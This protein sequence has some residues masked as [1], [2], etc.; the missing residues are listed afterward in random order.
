[1]AWNTRDLIRITSTLT[2]NYD[3]A[4]W[5]AAEDTA[6]NTA[7]TAANTAQLAASMATLEAIALARYEAEQKEIRA[8]AD[9]EFRLRDPD[10]WAAKQKQFQIARAAYELDYKRRRVADEEAHREADRFG[11]LVW[12]SLGIA[13]ELIFIA[14]ALAYLTT[15]IT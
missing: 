10:G 5:L 15:C 7:D 3:A 14:F 6:A 13:C 11:Q 4:A 12:I 1:M 8:K 2:G 9:E